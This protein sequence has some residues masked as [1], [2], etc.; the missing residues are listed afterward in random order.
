MGKLIAP[1]GL[2][3]DYGKRPDVVLG[4]MWSRFA[5]LVPAAVGVWIVYRRRK[6]AWLV[7]AAVCFVAP[8]LPVLGLKPFLMQYASTVADHYLYLAMLG[9]ALALTSLLTRHRE[10]GVAVACTLLFGAFAICCAAQ[11]RFW[12]DDITLCRHTLAVN[13]DSFTAFINLGHDLEQQGN[14]HAARDCFARA[15]ELQPDFALAQRNLAIEEISLKHWDQMEEHGKALIRLNRLRPPK[16]QRSFTGDFA[17]IGKQFMYQNQP[18]RAI[19]FLEEAV[20]IDPMLPDAVAD[21]A[22]AKRAMSTIKSP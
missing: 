17:L 5:W 13:S 9:P 19:P 12:K 15:V 21:L 22:E 14:F 3:V 18:A 8:L 10:P 7:A 16:A 4:S 6:R 20:R 11:A 1:I 2:A